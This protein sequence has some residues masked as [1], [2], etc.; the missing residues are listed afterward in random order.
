[1]LIDPFVASSPCLVGLRVCM[2]SQIKQA[3][4]ITA[5]EMKE[6]GQGTELAD[7]EDFK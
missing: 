3:R 2:R 7:Y 6:S 4:A 5:E 1:V